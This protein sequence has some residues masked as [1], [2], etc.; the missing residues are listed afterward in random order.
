M[1]I[2][3]WVCTNPAPDG[4]VP[5]CLKHDV[6]Y[7][8]LQKFAG[9]NPDNVIGGV[10]EGDEIDEAWNPRNK[11][12]ADAK[13]YADIRR[14]GCELEAVLWSILF[15]RINTAY[16]AHYFFTG[17][18]YFGDRDWPVTKEDIVHIGGSRTAH[19]TESSA[20]W[21]TLCPEIVP[22]T[23]GYVVTQTEGTGFN[24]VWRNNLRGCVGNVGGVEIA[25][26]ETCFLAIHKGRLEEGCVKGA[27]QPTTAF[28]SLGSDWDSAHVTR[29]NVVVRLFPRNRVYGGKYY[30]HL[31]V[32]PEIKRR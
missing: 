19:D 12:L 23:S 2:G 18:A 21:Y 6:A 29:G 8:S 13:F 7:G 30:E 15:C 14:Y 28:I 11:A 9:A 3:D 32:I 10:E 25:E 4:P 31:I 1:G 26:I 17:V 5:S 16:I 24:F 22:S 20:Y 27:G